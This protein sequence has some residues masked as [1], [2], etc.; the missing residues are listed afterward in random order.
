LTPGIGSGGGDQIRPGGLPSI[1]ILL[2]VPKQ[3]WTPENGPLFIAVAAEQHF[4]GSHNGWQAVQSTLML[5]EAF[6]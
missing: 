6:F 5:S 1:P 4:A 2:S 3:E